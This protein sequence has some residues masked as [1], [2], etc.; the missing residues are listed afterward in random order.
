MPRNSR[1]LRK[2]L[3]NIDFRIRSV[4]QEERELT[5]QLV[6][7]TYLNIV[8]AWP[9]FTYYSGANHRINISGTP[10]LRVEPSTRP[11]QPGALRGKAKQVQREQLAKLDN[12]PFETKNRRVLIGNAVPYASDVKYQAGLGTQIYT[13]AARQASESVR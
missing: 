1:E 5:I 13:E 3:D 9:A 10:V 11:D 8:E 4:Y 12:I 7:A 2:Y 6:R